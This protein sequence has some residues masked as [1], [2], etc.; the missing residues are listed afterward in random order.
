MG[1]WCSHVFVMERHF[2]H[3]PGQLFLWQLRRDRFRASGGKRDWKT[4]AKHRRAKKK[5][6]SQALQARCWNCMKLLHARCFQED[7]IYLHLLGRAMRYEAHST[8]SSVTRTGL[9]LNSNFVN[10]PPMTENPGRV[11]WTNTS[12]HSTNFWFSGF[13]GVSQGGS[14]K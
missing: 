10:I 12:T 3:G 9:P 1:L 13:Q 6:N 4:T 5:G 14:M 7:S 11:S 8:L 2:G